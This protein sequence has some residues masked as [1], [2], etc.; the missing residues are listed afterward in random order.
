MTPRI[1]V[2]LLRD[3][4]QAIIASQ[5]REEMSKTDIVNRAVVLYEF[6]MAQIADGNEVLV[7]HKDGLVEKVRIL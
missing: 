1:T 2:G 6:V 4:E 5:V 3:A 7:R